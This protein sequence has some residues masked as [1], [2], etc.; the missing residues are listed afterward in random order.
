MC[1]RSDQY[2]KYIT[3]HFPL[4]KDTLLNGIIKNYQE[5]GFTCLQ[6]NKHKMFNTSKIPKRL[7]SSSTT[8][9]LILEIQNV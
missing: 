8:N 5:K 2:K 6:R 4:M 1:F 9:Q 3:H 7:L